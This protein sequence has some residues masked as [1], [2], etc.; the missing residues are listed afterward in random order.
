MR[1]N[2]INGENKLVEPRTH[3][4]LRINGENMIMARTQLITETSP[5]IGGSIKSDEQFL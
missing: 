1:K 4:I 2:E 3:P 5:N